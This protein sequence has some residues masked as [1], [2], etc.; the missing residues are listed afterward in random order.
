MNT[1]SAADATIEKF[2][3][4]ALRV[5][6]LCEDITSKIASELQPVLP[7]EQKE[8]ASTDGYS[9]RIDETTNFLFNR[10]RELWTSTSTTTCRFEE[11]ER[12]TDRLVQRIDG[13]TTKLIVECGC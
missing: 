9:N 8:E 12:L 5:D 4:L 3:Q 13:R 1:T 2:L 7:H 11:F 10:L 6:R